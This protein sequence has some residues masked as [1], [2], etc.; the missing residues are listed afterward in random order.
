VRGQAQ[1]G[2]IHRVALAAELDAF[3]HVP[4]LEAHVEAPIGQACHRA[5]HQRIGGAAAPLRHYRA[6]G[7]IQR[8]IRIDAAKR[9]AALQI[10]AHDRG[11]RL[12]RFFF[13]A[14]AHDG[15]GQ[16]GRADA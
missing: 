7:F 3:D 4:Q 6:R 16:L 10:G 11:D 1:V 2:R 9:A 14:K 15:D 13:I 5:G 8:A 12:A